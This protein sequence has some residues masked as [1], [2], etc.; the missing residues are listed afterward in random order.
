MG[1]QTPADELSDLFDRTAASILK[2]EHQASLEGMELSGA[3]TEPTS[4]GYGVLVR[5]YSDVFHSLCDYL[6]YKSE[7][8]AHRKLIEEKKKLISFSL[9][10]L[11]EFHAAWHVLRKE[12]PS[13]SE[14]EFKNL[15][16]EQRLRMFADA[17]EKKYNE[18]PELYEER[19]KV[20]TLCVQ[21]GI[22]PEDYK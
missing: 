21:T 20:I 15:D 3:S 5:F 9:S 8:P 12:N 13:L 2:D 17:L 7:N 1:G 16:A 11:V 19:K 18:M 4:F 6:S 14:D 22:L 10:N